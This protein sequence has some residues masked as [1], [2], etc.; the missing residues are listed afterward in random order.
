MSAYVIANLHELSPGPGVVAYIQA[1]DA[2]LVPFGGRFIVHGAPPQVLEGAWSGDTVILEFPGVPEARAW[3]A[4][5]GY[6][7][8]KPLRTAHYEGPVV[9][10]QGVP[11]DHRSIDLLTGPQALHAGTTS[12]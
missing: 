3:Y 11:A 8:I 7:A 9:L 4:S 6:Q 1:I 5:D 12:M 2:T 10:I